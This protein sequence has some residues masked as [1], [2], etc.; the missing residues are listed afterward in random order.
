[1]PRPKSLIV[2]AK[3]VGRS[4]DDKVG[5]MGIYVQVNRAVDEI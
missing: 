3:L 5:A 1:M 4:E 2:A